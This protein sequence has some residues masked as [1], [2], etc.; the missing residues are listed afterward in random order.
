MSW[1]EIIGAIMVGAVFFIPW[2]MVYLASYWED[3][4]YRQGLRARRE[5]E[6]GREQAA[7]ASDP[8]WI[9][10]LDKEENP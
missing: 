4:G 1:R 2:I 10:P 8:R 3:A 5:K 9:S 7:G 6:K